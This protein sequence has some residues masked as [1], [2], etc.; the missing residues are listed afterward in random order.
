M[1]LHPVV[2]DLVKL[3][4]ERISAYEHAAGLARYSFDPYATRK[5][6]RVDPFAPGGGDRLYVDGAPHMFLPRD[7][8]I[9]STP[10]ERRE[11][12]LAS[13]WTHDPKSDEWRKPR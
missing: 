6:T 7:V 8:K 1:P 9:V 2:G 4:S 5:V 10:A 12:L 11:M 3:K 13:G